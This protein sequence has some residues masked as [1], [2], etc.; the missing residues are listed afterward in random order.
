MMEG[1]E[2]EDSEEEEEEEEDSEEEVIRQGRRVRN[3]GRL[4]WLFPR[5]VL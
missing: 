2:E 4:L 1:D 5:I 3:V